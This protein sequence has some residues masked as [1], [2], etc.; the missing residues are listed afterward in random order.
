[1]S[2]N[3]SSE[4]AVDVDVGDVVADVADVEEFVDNRRFHDSE[5]QT[6]S[7]S[8]SSASISCTVDQ[9]VQVGE[10]P[11]KPYQ[12]YEARKRSDI[13]TE[14]IEKIQGLLH[15]YVHGDSFAAS[16]LAQDLVQS[17][18]WCTTFG[19]HEKKKESM[20]SQ[21]RCSVQL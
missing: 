17:K 13:R 11:A 14:L 20:K 16:D 3:N 7:A 6:D 2:Q 10:F 9:A 18:K 19:L 8:I 4:D 21:R 1:M 5:T 12:C 15:G